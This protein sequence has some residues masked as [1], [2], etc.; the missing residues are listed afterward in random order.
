MFPTPRWTF[1][2]TASSPQ[3]EVQ[4]CPLC[5]VEIE[6]CPGRPDK[7]IFSQ[8]TPGTRSKLW[9]RVCQFLKTPEQ[10]AACINQDPERRG[11]QQVGDA[12]PDAPTIDLGAS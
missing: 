12:F 8:G 9:S 7:V 6:T 3:A 4:R 1:T 5:Q 11:P 2:V 10:T